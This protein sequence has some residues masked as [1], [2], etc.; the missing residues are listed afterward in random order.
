VS[1]STVRNHVALMLDAG[2]VVRHE[3]MLSKGSTDKIEKA[4]RPISAIRLSHAG[5]DF[6]DTIRKEEIWEKTK[7]EAASAG[8]F[9]VDLLKDLAKGFIKTK[10]EEHTGV[11]L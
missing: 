11:K 6:L 9:T 1:A 10:I 3:A 4:K 5:Y 7:K 8:G 2:L